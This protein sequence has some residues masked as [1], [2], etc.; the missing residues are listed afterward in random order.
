MAY[1]EPCCAERQLPVLIRESRGFCFFQTAGDVTI[2]KLYQATASLVSNEPKTMLL[3]V[4]E[5]DLSLMRF[6]AYAFRRKWLCGLLLLTQTAQAALVEAEL[7]DYL[8][9]VHYAA[10]PMVLDGLCVIVNE[11]LKMKNE[12]FAT[13]QGGN[14]QLSTLNSQLNKA[15]ILQGPVLSHTDP[16]VCQYVACLTTSNDMVRQATDA[17][18]AKLRLKPIIDHSDNEAVAAVLKRQF[19]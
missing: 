2:E 4:P 3:V 1:I 18:V 16:S 14:S 15:L 12:E 8:A 19:V 9:A 13:A 7:Q 5:A 6:L 10:D 17:V 11:E